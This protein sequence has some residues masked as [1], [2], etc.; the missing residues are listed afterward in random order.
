VFFEF[1]GL[2]IFGAMTSPLV[3]VAVLM[4]VLLNILFYHL[5]KAPTVLGRRV[6]DHIEGFK[7][8]LE[9]AEEERL[10]ML[11]SPEKTP[12][13]FEKLLPYA[14]ALDVEVEWTKK[15]ADVLV[16]SRGES[17]YSPLWYSGGSPSTFGVSGF[18]AGLGSAL[19]GAISSS[20]T[21]PGSSSGSGGG[22]SSGG[23][24]GGG[25][26]GGW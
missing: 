24:G 13:L 4:I 23:G 8:Y 1:F 6:M 9:T 22:G 17:E 14:L 16:R 26:G 2:V 15:F 21:A 18:T 10:N 25:G 5:L 20:S 11:S 7:M 3:V 12:Q 19:S